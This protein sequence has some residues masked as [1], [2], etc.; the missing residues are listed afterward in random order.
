MAIS[1]GQIIVTEGK[2]SFESGGTVLS[3]DGEIV[4]EEVAQ[5]MY[6]LPEMTI[7]VEGH[8]DNQGDSSVLQIRSLNMA[9]TV[10]DGLMEQGV[11][12]GR[13]EVVGHGGSRPLDTNRTPDGRE[14]NNRVELHITSE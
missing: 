5:L 8:T 13:M 7:R 10:R 1:Y 2:F 12:T 11:Q 9:E 14:A 3:L 6:D 4:L